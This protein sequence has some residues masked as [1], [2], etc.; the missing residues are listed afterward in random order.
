MGFVSV[1]L[2]GGLGNYLFQIASAYSKSIDDNLSFI[3]DINDITI[4]HSNPNNYKNNIFR[5]LNFQ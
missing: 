1:K 4:V 3:L 2:M 5:K